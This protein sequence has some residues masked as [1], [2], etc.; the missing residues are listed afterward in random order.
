MPL[1]HERAGSFDTIGGVSRAVTFLGGRW[2]N[3]GVSTS[4]T[5]T[6][7]KGRIGFY[8]VSID[9]GSFEAA[10]NVSFAVEKGASFG[11]VGESGSGK[12]TVLRALSGLNPDWTGAMRVDGQALDR[13]RSKAFYKLVQMV[14]QDP[15]GSLHPRHTVD[16]VLA[17]LHGLAGGIVVF[18]LW[19]DATAKPAKRV[20]IRAV[21]GSAQPMRL[22]A[23]LILYACGWVFRRMS[24]W[25]KG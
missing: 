8:H 11:I 16:H 2:T 24:A 25:A 19:P 5:L 1:T 6:P 17:E 22:A 21:K 23:G 4:E 9:F 7:V 12:S 18:P 15:Y 20:L 14:F 3:A 13:K 10:R